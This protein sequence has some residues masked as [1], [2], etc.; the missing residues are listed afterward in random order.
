[1]TI[2]KVFI[3]TS[4][5]Y[6]LMDRSDSY[7]QSASKLWIHFLD[8]GYDLK[9]SNYVTIETLALLQNRLGFEAADIWS[10]DILGIVET[11]WIDEVLHNLAFE[12]WFS[13]GRRKL[14]LVDC[15]SFVVMRHDKVEKVFGF[16]KHLTEHGFEVLNE[17]AFR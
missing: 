17:Q 3:D 11:I 16:D 6:A 13:L 12:I 9:T 2:E 7:H 10:R 15:A 8:Q 4:A 5:F 1:M 14:S